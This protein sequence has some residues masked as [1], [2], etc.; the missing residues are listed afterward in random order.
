M[1]AHP[2]NIAAIGGKRIRPRRRRRVKNPSRTG[3]LEVARALHRTAQ[4]DLAMFGTIGLALGALSTLSSIV[5]SAAS[6]ISTAA[7]PPP[8]QTFTAHAASSAQSSINKAPLNP[9]VPIPKFDKHT[10]AALLALQEQHL[11]A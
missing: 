11:R 1:F 10:H 9:G 5:E 6:S 7:N 3:V 2:A 4:E 8:A